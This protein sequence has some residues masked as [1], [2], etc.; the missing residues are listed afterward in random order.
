[1]QNKGK[2]K[3]EEKNRC[4]PDP[5]WLKNIWKTKPN[6][7]IRDVEFYRS[8]SRMAVNKI[9]GGGKR[10]DNGSYQIREEGGMYR[11]VGEM[12]KGGSH[13][14]EEWKRVSELWRRC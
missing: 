5:K 8:R 3:I 14:R 2:I 13:Q 7:V 9:Y 6:D 4:R 11:R 12:R 1:M 10:R